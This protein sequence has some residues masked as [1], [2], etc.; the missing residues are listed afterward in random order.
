MALTVDTEP[1]AEPILKA[2]A[3][4][5]LRVDHTG[6]DTYITTLCTVA[7]RWAERWTR[8]A[9]IT[10]TLRLT[11]DAL[12]GFDG[13]IELPR[14]PLQSIT[15]IAYID[16][17]GASQT[18]AASKYR[19]ETK[20]APGRVEPA[21]G[22]TWPSTRSIVGAVTIIYKAGYGTG[23]SSVPAEM[24]Q[25]MLLLIG[26]LYSHREITVV[27][28]S[29]STLETVKNLLPAPIQLVRA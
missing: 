19:V 3:K 26:D 18:L 11:L 1:A 8:R 24:I 6:D 7:R 14:P 25:A 15:S 27:G 10:Q 20:S 17:A 29:T 23:G 12:P 4:T 5:H 13:I 9:M 16:T 21:W 28:I 2:E 22:E